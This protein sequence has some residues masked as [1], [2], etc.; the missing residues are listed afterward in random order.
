MRRIAALLTLSCLAVGGVVSSAYAS[1]HSTAYSGKTNQHR[2]IRLKV[3]GN[4]LEL[5]SFT[6]QLHCRDGS[7]LVD[8]ESGFQP[9]ALRGNRFKEAQFGSTDTVRMAGHVKA[10]KVIGTL[11]VTDKL[12]KVRCTSPTVKFT[13]D[14]Q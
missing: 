9:S 12:G 13:A 6:I 8:Q 1:P 10:A 11:K 5:K 3:S 7:V 2:A 4:R 14:R